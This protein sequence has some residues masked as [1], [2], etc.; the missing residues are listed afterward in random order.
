MDMR[1]RSFVTVLRSA[2]R[3]RLLHSPAVLLT[4]RMEKVAEFFDEQFF[5]RIRVIGF[6]LE[7][8]RL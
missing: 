7:S 5:Q 6:A 4:R 1:K 3:P 8:D 2:G